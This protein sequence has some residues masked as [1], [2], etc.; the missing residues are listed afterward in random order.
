M[1]QG[2]SL[3]NIC[4][5]LSYAFSRSFALGQGN[6]GAHLLHF[7][8][9]PCRSKLQASTVAAVFIP[10]VGCFP[11]LGH[12]P[13]PCWCPSTSQASHMPFIFTPGSQA[14]PGSASHSSFQTPASSCWHLSLSFCPGPSHPNLLCLCGSCHIHFC[15][16]FFSFFP[17]CDRI[18]WSLS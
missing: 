13:T 12:L 5:V 6:S 1:T 7:L 8:R 2:Q 9:L 14:S 18:L 10:C 15:S 16:F 11:S 4:Q 3:R 17:F